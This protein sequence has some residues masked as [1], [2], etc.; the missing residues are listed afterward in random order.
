ME[1]KRTL[2]I[3]AAAG[4]FLLVVVGAALILYSPSLSKNDQ[5]QTYYNPRDG[6]TNGQKPVTPDSNG[7]VAP[8]ELA[9]AGSGALAPAEGIAPVNTNPLAV[10]PQDPAALAASGA[11]TNIEQMY[12]QANSADGQTLKA[13]NVTVIT[14]NALVYGTGT[15]TTI[16]LNALKSNPAAVSSAITPKNSYTA[17]QINTQAQ[18]AKETAKAPAD[19][20]YAPAPKKSV[21]KKEAAPKKTETAKAAAKKTVKA[22]PKKT[23]PDTFWIQVGSYEAKKSADEARSILESNKI[24]NEVFTYKDSKG[25]LFYRVRVGP[26]TTKS[27]AEYWQS[28]ILMINQFAKASSYVVKN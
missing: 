24:P 23:T 28:R 11:N 5:V 1:Q 20:Y 16:D 2:W 27:E 12:A 8:V 15:T 3:V 6:W 21:P 9:Q 25:K 7:G 14:D 10:N 17:E 4:V 18:A 26:Y 22:E 13:E 19:T